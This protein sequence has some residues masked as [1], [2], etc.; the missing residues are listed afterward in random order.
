MG[1]DERNG[2]WLLAGNV[3]AAEVAFLASFF[4]TYTRV[5]IT[6]TTET[7][8]MVK[9][10]IGL[11][12][13]ALAVTAAMLPGTSN[14]EFIYGGNTNSWIGFIDFEEGPQSFDVT[15]NVAVYNKKFGVD[16]NPYGI[17]ATDVGDFYDSFNL[18]TSS[19][20]LAT[21]L[22]GAE[23]YLYLYQLTNN[24]TDAIHEASSMNIS[25]GGVL[26]SW[27]YFDGFSLEDDDGIVNGASD[28]TA[29]DFGEDAQVF[30]DLAFPSGPAVLSPGVTDS[31]AASSYL[32]PVQV[33]TVL[34]KF[35]V[36]F[37][38]STSGAKIP[39]GESSVVFGFTSARGPSYRPFTV[40][41]GGS[42]N[43]TTVA[44]GSVTG[45]APT[46]PAPTGLMALAS[47]ATVGFGAF[48]RRRRAGK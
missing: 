16:G 41:D 40:Q 39:A 11:T 19:A 43:G 38:D 30:A 35:H 4:E 32:D 22:A 24:G 34:D 8:M 28:A 1:F 27:G 29:N 42:V 2:F 6:H 20:A 13:M 5:R 18:G 15:L 21:A 26:T 46:V 14:A 36:L 17:S 12:L 47:L 48:Y 31:G 3:L 10:K 37:V 9:K 7:E 44:P 45:N 23:D 33:Y 25:F